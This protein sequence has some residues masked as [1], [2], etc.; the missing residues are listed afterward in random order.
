MLLARITIA[1]NITESSLSVNIQLLISDTILSTEHIL[2]V[3]ELALLAKSGYNLKGRIA[4]FLL[5]YGD[6]CSG[7]GHSDPKGLLDTQ[8]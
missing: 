5:T 1:C 2:S 4:K 6:N 8:F 7:T 3:K